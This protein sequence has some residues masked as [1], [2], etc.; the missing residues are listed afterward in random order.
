MK[1]VLLNP[2]MILAAIWFTGCTVVVH[3]QKR[4]PPH[5]PHVSRVPADGTIE[6]INAVGKL[7][8]EPHRRDAYKRIAKRPELSDAAQEHL[9]N[10][11]FDNL[12]FEPMKR[13]VLMALI[14]NPCFSPAGRQAILSQLDRL[15][16]ESTKTEILEAISRR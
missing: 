4:H 11:V 9:V 16:F 15:S 7:S 5:E 6:E 1:R 13:D 8:F 10:A 3:E 2:V 12:S 14:S